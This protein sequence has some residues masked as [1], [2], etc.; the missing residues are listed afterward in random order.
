MPVLSID[1]ADF[2][3][4]IEV[5]AYSAKL[6]VYGRWDALKVSAYPCRYTGSMYD[7]SLVIGMGESAVMQSISVGDAVYITDM[8]GLCYAYGVSDVIVTDDV[9]TE[10]LTSLDADLV[11]FARRSYS[12]EYTVVCCKN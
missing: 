9:S 10:H 5:P 8:T 12:G 7:G 4:I 2:A 1:G 11:L 3:A 6:P